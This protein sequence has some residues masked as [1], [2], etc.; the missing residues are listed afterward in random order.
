MTRHGDFHAA[1]ERVAVNC[2]DQRLPRILDATEQRVR[3]GRTRQRIFGRL[4]RF[5]DFDVGAGD[6]RSARADQHDRIGVGV[7]VR[8]RHGLVETCPDRWAECVD[9]ADYQ[10]SRPQRGL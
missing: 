10:W 8:A 2:G 3:A 5:E 7:A 9:R 6:K 4:Q 1:A